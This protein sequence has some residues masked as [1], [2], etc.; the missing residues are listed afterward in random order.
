MEVQITTNRQLYGYVEAYIDELLNGDVTYQQVL[1]IRKYITDRFLV[2]VFLSAVGIHVRLLYRKDTPVY[3]TPLGFELL[4]DL[5]CY[6]KDGE[7]HVK[8]G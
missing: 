6:M 5:F 3:P 7:V 8:K 2:V 1:G 4:V